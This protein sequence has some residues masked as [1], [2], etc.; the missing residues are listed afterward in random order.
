[1][2]ENRMHI[3]NLGPGD[4]ALL[5]NVSDEAADKAI[6]R[7]LTAMG[8][9]PDKPIEMQAGF[10][11]LRKASTD[12]E[13]SADFA[14]TRRNRRRTEGAFGKAILTTVGLSAA[15]ALHSMWAGF[16]A[17]AATASN[18]IGLN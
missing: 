15:G 14:W 10:A 9:D 6:R 3:G 7:W 12:P 1:M 13:V 16:K 5:R 18:T 2:N 8:M 17:L 4:I 11:L